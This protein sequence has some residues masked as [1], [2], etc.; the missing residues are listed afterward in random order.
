MYNEEPGSLKGEVSSW[1]MMTGQ[2]DS[3]LSYSVESNNKMQGAPEV[4]AS[5]PP[6]ISRHGDKTGGY[7]GLSRGQETGQHFGSLTLINA[8]CC[9]LGCLRTCSPC[10]LGCLRT[11]NKESPKGTTL[12]LNKR[13]C[14]SLAMFVVS[15]QKRLQAP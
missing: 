1:V 8:L 7:L 13:C 5:P 14:L 12:C 6:S 2:R 4:K 9:N 10:R 11:H 3:S 15:R